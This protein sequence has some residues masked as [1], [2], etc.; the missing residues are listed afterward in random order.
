[1]PELAAI[2][3]G[4]EG[5]QA[6]TLPPGLYYP[7]H[8]HLSRALG[9]VGSM[10]NI[11][12]GSETE[13]VPLNGPPFHPQFFSPE[14]FK[15][16]TSIFEVL[17]GNVEPGALSQAAQWLDLYLNSAAGVRE[18]ALALDPLHRALAVAYEG[19]SAIRE[20]ETADFPET[21]RSGLKAL[22]R[23]CIERY[24][25]EFATLDK[26]QQSSVIST[27]ITATPNSPLQTFFD[28]MRDTAVRGY[29]TTAAGLKELDYKGNWYYASCPGCEHKK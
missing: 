27:V 23:H 19:E 13:Y 22:Q 12:P 17:L 1:L 24:G 10:H 8:D 2:S 20:L 15:L 4:A 3:F 6:T 18:A 14:E 21:V 28:L 26:E 29:Y 9:E 11:P 5:H 16:I 25:R 7:S